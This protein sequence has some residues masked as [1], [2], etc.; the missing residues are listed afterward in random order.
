MAKT[1]KIDPK[2]VSKVTTL[3][4]VT[5]AEP[6]FADNVK[7]KFK[8]YIS[9]QISDLRG[10]SLGQKAAMS[11]FNPVNAALSV[12]TE[13]PLP[14]QQAMLKV[15]GLPTKMTG[16]DLD[17]SQKQ[18]LYNAMKNAKQRH[19]KFVSYGDYGPQGD[20]IA[21]GTIK[22][23]VNKLISGDPTFGVA[24][25]LGR[26]GVKETADSMIYTDKYDF[27]KGAF[28][29]EK[30]PNLYQRFRTYLGDSEPANPSQTDNDNM[31]VRIALAK[32]DFEN[33]VTPKKS[34]GT[35][36]IPPTVKSTSK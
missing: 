3:K 23:K 10:K 6:S 18:V 27:S 14:A 1:R 19:D 28:S 13:L 24:T 17:N 16:K 21:Q 4:K 30:N 25:T 32:K 33:K 15:A 9:D 12:F 5:A 7:G 31:A 34:T 8:N 22:G 36:T 20:S 35:T 26:G 29:K 2:S 11:V